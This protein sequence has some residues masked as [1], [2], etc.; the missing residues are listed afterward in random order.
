MGSFRGMYNASMSRVLKHYR[1]YNGRY[2]PADIHPLTPF[3]AERKEPIRSL[4][5][6]PAHRSRLLSSAALWYTFEAMSAPEPS[7]EEAD[8]QLIRVDETDGVEDRDELRG[9][10]SWAIGTTPRYTSSAYGPVTLPARAVRDLRVSAT[11]PRSFSI[12]FSLLPGGEWFDLPYDEALPM[13]IC[14]NRD[15]KPRPTASKR[16]PYTCRCPLNNTRI[17][18]YHKLVHLSA[19]RRYR[20]NSSCESVDRM[21]SRPWFVLSSAQEYYYRNYHIDYI[22]LPPV[23]PG[24]G[25]DLNR[26]IELIYPEA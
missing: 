9:R 12:S 16:T 1:T 21:I 15:I 11:P 7:E 14:R 8:W 3:P 18:P 2:N 17:C 5:D 10:D 13:A 24:C 25:Q 4:T 26:Q 23:K 19:D 6:S 20:V 22:P